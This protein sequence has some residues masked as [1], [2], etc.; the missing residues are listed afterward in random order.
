MS[1]SKNS[2]TPKAEPAEDL[3][4]ERDIDEKFGL[5]QEG[6]YPGALPDNDQEQAVNEAVR[7][8]LR[9]NQSK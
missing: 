2:E 5:F 1:S 4:T 6:T 7:T 3:V 8:H 9:A